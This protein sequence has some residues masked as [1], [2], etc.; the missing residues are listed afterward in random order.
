MDP[1]TPLPITHPVVPSENGSINNSQFVAATATASHFLDSRYA[2]R[3][4]IDQ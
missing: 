3:P 1:L 2:N 4:Q